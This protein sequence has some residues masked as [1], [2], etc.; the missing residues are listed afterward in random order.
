MELLQKYWMWIL[1]AVALFV[2]WP[3]GRG[4]NSNQ[5]AVLAASQTSASTSIALSQ[6][7]Q[8]DN[9][10]ARE[11]Q[12]AM[13][14]LGQVREEVMLNTL[15]SVGQSATHTLL[16]TQAIRAQSRTDQLAIESQLEAILDSN[17]TSVELE[18]LSTRRDIKLAETQ[19]F[20]DRLVARLQI[21]LAQIHETTQRQAINAGIWREQIQGQTQQYFADSQVRIAE[22]SSSADIF[23]QIIGALG[24]A[25]GAY[26]TGGASLAAE[27]F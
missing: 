14:A 16:G 27:A 6:I 21:P 3:R 10:S 8:Q 19:A 1:A 9:A 20:T 22:I 15:M 4:A 2:L 23:G 12:V 13:A 18:K 11:A 24:K 7:Q 25:A 26:F 5:G 17:K